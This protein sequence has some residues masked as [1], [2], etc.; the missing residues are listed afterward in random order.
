MNY[1]DHEKEISIIMFGWMLAF[2]VIEYIA[3]EYI[4]KTNH[5]SKWILSWNFNDPIT[6]MLGCM[7]FPIIMIMMIRRF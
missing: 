1:K 6:V 5:I 4:I 2:G 3:K 7:T